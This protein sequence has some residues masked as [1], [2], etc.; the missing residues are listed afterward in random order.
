[1]ALTSGQ[2]S[3]K[4][5]G[6]YLTR[7][8]AKRE[9]L[10][11]TNNF[12][13]SQSQFQLTVRLVTVRRRQGRPWI[14][15]RPSV[16]DDQAGRRPRCRLHQPRLSDRRSCA[17]DPGSADGAR[18]ADHR[19][20]ESP[21]LAVL[22]KEAETLKGSTTL[23]GSHYLEDAVFRERAGVIR[24]QTQSFAVVVD[25]DESGH[26]YRRERFFDPQE[27][28]D[29]R[30]FKW[31][32]QTGK[33]RLQCKVPHLSRWRGLGTWPRSA[34]HRLRLSPP[35]PRPVRRA[36]Q[37]I[38]STHQRRP[39]AHVSPGRVV[40]APSLWHRFPPTGA[41]QRAAPR[42]RLASRRSFRPPGGHECPPVRLRS[43][44]VGATRLAERPREEY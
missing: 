25:V 13:E 17:A 6:W 3:G 35:V 11:L 5:V 36:S 44:P 29:H 38:R 12:P 21:L 24:D 20:S 15:R 8:R 30:D 28:F 22:G 1:M 2:G 4:R 27:G 37:A 39:P 40:I 10:E 31:V 19:C 18:C 23:L 32:K 14:R 33:D 7:K 34:R 42:R 43:C 26:V 9:Y 41:A 16:N